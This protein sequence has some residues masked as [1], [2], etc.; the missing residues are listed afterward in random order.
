MSSECNNI[1]HQGI[2]EQ[3]KNNTIFVKII[4]SS[5]CAICK[6]KSLCSVNDFKEMLVDIN[7]NNASIYKPGQT[8]TVKMKKSL[9]GKAVLLAY[10]IPFI[11]MMLSLIIL[12]LLNFSEL[13]AGLFS[14]GILAPYYLVLYLLKNKLSKTF[15]FT[16]SP[17]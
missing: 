14:I 8:V 6:A 12:T 13:F 7:V 15:K 1:T 11:I 5:A 17:D 9:G 16:I 3:I 10:I 2:V 4:V